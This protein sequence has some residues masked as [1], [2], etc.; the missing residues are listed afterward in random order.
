MYL[1]NLYS[2][3]AK[4]Q[5][6]GL[7]HIY[8]QGSPDLILDLCNDCWNGKTVSELSKSQRKKLFDLY[9]RFSVSSYCTAFS[10]KPLLKSDL[11]SG[12]SDKVLRFPPMYC[13]KMTNSQN[14]YEKLDLSGTNDSDSTIL[15]ESERQSLQFESRDSA[16]DVNRSIGHSAGLQDGEI[17]QALDVN[18]NQ[19]FLGMVS[20]QYKAKLV[21]RQSN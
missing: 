6:N 10:F 7:D 15:D 5:L 21:R 16:Q 18:S 2:V 17:R 13:D 14:Y 3:I 20:T 1:S 11:P 8:S 19:I 4:C 9:Q 12:L